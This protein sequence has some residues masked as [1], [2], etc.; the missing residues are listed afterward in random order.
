[1]TRTTNKGFVLVSVLWVLA[2]LTVISLGFGHRALMER[3]L[4]TYSADYG[5]ALYAARGNAERGIVELRNATA[6]RRALGGEGRPVYRPAWR[7]YRNLLGEQNLY[8]AGN[9]PDYNR[10]E[11]SYTIRHANGK[12]NVNTASEEL[13]RQLPGFSRRL[14][15][16]IVRRRERGGPRGSPAPFRTLEELRTLRGFSDENWYGDRRN[17]PAYTFLCAYDVND[18][19]QVDV[20]TATV[21]VLQ[22]LPG[23]NAGLAKDIAV[24]RDGEDEIPG[25]PDDVY[26][27]SIED[28]GNIFGLSGAD[29]AEIARFATTSS[30]YYVVTGLATLRSPSPVD[31]N[32]DLAEDTAPT[33]PGVTAYCE[34]LVRVDGGQATVLQWREGPYGS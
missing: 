2:L 13:L 31:G 18:G 10:E 5:K 6:I 21:D 20:N 16:E 34:A 14:A 28:L 23:V 30:N 1:M 7:P 24:F 15:R 4:A 25:T 22:A 32:A 12:V 11:W 26:F 17:P 19:G 9:N 33:I 8:A 29:L 27:R 3:R